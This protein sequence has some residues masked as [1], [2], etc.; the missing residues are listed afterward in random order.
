MSGI[1]T[2]RQ[3]SFKS[4]AIAW[5]FMLVATS[6]IFAQET[7]WRSDL[8]ER[9]QVNG[10]DVRVHK[11][12]VVL[13]QPDKTLYC[14]SAI[15]YLTTKDVV[16]IGNVRLEQNTGEILT[17]DSLTYK[18]TTRIAT[19]TGRTVQLINKQSVLTTT[20]LDYNMDDGFVRYRK[21][22]TIKDEKSTLVSQYGDYDRN[23]KVFYFT[24]DVVLT[25]DKSTLVTDTLHYYA[26]QKMAYFYG[27]S[28]VTSPDGVIQSIKGRYNTETEKSFLEGRSF[29]DAT[30]Y[31]MTADI[32][33][34]DKA[35]D[36]GVGHG[37]VIIFS[38]KD[39]AIITGEHGFYDGNKG[40]SKV[41]QGAL[42]RSPAELIGPLGAERKDTIYLRADTLYAIGSQKRKD[43]KQRVFAWPKARVYKTN[44]QAIADSLVYEVS[45]SV[46]ILYKDPVVWSAK[47][48]ITA[49]TIKAYSRNQQLYRV[50]VRK[51]AFAVS[52]D[53]LGNFNQTKGRNMLAHFKK[54]K[55]DRIDVDGNGQSIYWVLDG[56]TAVSGMNK[57]ICSDMIARFNAKGK[58]SKIT[59]IKEPDA[60]FTP[61]QEL[62]EPDTRLKG[63]KWRASERPTLLSMVGREKDPF[64]PRVFLPEKKKVEGQK[65][66]STVK[67]VKKKSKT[68][69][70]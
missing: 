38:K 61:P 20:E 21:G 2:I 16:F 45:D 66:K 27:P 46:L 10:V 1:A 53:T 58:L 23:K 25:G 67:P 34:Y 59:F 14:D 18:R 50:Y 39:S 26:D 70:K 51:D 31:T 33:D 40:V 55:I 30:D 36:R 44:I 15:E 6:S 62:K 57:V 24:K 7:N 42:M 28:T 8:M 54:G 63:F 65:K 11:G 35:G 17:G 32:L 69:R 37:K 3:V 56:D 13:T 64:T 49:D 29:I 5:I 47:N 43:L 48:Q 9:K 52:I 41:W 60:V 12:S 22:A 68:L 19:M 4:L